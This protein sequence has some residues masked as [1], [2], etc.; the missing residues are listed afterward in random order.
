MFLKSDFL[1]IEC[2]LNLIEEKI[3]KIMAAIDDLN[4]EVTALTAL[5]V[6][7]T[8]ITNALAGGNVA[9]IEAA[10]TNLK[11]TQATIDAFTTKLNTP[12]S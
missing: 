10:V 1:K 6:A 9:A 8:A 12:S 7:T 2:K 3:N 4:A 5:A 11:A